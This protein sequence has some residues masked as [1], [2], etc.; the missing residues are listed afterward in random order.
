MF[1]GVMLKVSS[2]TE[3]FRE[4]LSKT[5]RQQ[6][7]SSLSIKLMCIFFLSSGVQVALAVIDIVHLKMYH[8]V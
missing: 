5:F 3:F 4:G 1:N 8:P 2:S 6:K 7:S